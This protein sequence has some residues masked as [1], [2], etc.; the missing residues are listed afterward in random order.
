MKI[1]I[2]TQARTTSSRLPGKVLL[3]INEKTLLEYHLERL[4]ESG[5]E[6]FVATTTNME[7][8]P[9]VEIAEQNKIN[10]HR[11]REPEGGKRY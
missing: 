3:E 10:Y 7:D 8:D 2:I 5:L 4:K 1:G 11:G 6:R 9:I